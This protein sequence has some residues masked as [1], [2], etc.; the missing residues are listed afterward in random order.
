MMKYHENFFFSCFHSFFPKLFEKIGNI[1][2]KAE[3]I[4]SGLGES[5]DTMNELANIEILKEGDFTDSIQAWL[6][7]VSAN[8][9]GKI[10]SSNLKIEESKPYVSLD[11][12]NTFVDCWR[13]QE[14][15]KNFITTCMEAPQTLQELVTEAVALADQAKGN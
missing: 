9:D 12:G 7:S 5:T 1:L 4:R 15:L 3:A 14:A 8:C 2:E 11:L 13:F 6:W 10:Q